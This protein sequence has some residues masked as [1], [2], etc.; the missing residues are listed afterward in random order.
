MKLRYSYHSEHNADAQD[1]WMHF[2]FFL[3]TFFLYFAAGNEFFLYFTDWHS[4]VD[5]SSL[6]HLVLGVIYLLAGSFLLWA[7]I[8]AVRHSRGEADRY[9]RVDD[10]FVTWHL[11]QGVAE[12]SVELAGIE[13]VKRLNVRE[14][15][16]GL[17]GG[18]SATLPIYLIA[19][20]E[21]Q[22]ELVRVLSAGG[23]GELSRKAD[24]RDDVLS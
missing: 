22:N 13:S 18:T 4:D 2:I 7:G 10:E 16:L 21:K 14:L 8:R 12:Q 20:E 5:D 23:A 19:N 11:E 6:R 17:N 3:G 1:R 24:L 9:V 15:A